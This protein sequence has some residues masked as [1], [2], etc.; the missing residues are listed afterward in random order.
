MSAIVSASEPAM[1]TL[2]L[3]APDVASVSSVYLPSAPADRARPSTRQ[4][5]AVRV[6]E[7][8]GADRRRVHDLDQVDRDRGADVRGAALVALPF[9]LDGRIGVI[10]RA[11]LTAPRS[12]ERQVVRQARRSC[13]AVMTAIA[14]AA[15]T[16]TVVPPPSPL[17]AVGVFVLPGVLAAL[18][19]R[20]ARSRRRGSRRPSRSR[21]LSASSSVLRRRSSQ[22]R[23]AVLLPGSPVGAGGGLGVVGRG[24]V[25]READ[26]SAGGEVA[27]ELRD[28]RRR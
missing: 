22:T 2:P 23:S 10:G 21:A 8:V 4:G 6:D 14:A 11:E 17:D 7:A 9:A 24:A 1:P 20:R 19:C 13:C 18:D 3:P 16:V 5:Q 12:A 28:R 15:A 27:L 25:R 26:R